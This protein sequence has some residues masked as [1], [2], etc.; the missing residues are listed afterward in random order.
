MK[1]EKGE[2]TKGILLITIKKKKHRLETALKTS[3]NKNATH[4]TF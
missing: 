3:D 2:S 1:M 4:G